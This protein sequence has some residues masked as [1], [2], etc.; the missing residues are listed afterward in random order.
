MQEKW[1]FSSTFL[2]YTGEPIEFMLEDRNQPIHG[3]FADGVFHS[4]WA[5]YDPE[6]VASWR[7]SDGDP[8]HAPMPKA[9]AA[10]AG[11]FIT[12]LRRLAKILSGGRYAASIEPLHSHARTPEMRAIPMPPIAVAARRIH[13]NQISS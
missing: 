7:E 4:R 12:T 6:R 11:T 8:S 13:S 2:P 9:K 10:P 1:I 5:D 3:T